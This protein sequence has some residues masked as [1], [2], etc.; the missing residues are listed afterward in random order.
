M[1]L[2][3]AIYCVCDVNRDVA[4]IVHDT[5]KKYIVFTGAI[6]KKVILT[7]GYTLKVT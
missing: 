7:L 5:L 6:Q 2:I 4:T 3:R 1:M